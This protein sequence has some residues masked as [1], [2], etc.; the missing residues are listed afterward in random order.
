MT[1][2]EGET[3]PRNQYHITNIPFIAARDFRSTII[4]DPDLIEDAWDQK[5]E[6]CALVRNAV[7]IA[8][9]R[10]VHPVNLRLPV[11]D[12]FHNLPVAENDRQIGRLVSARQ[13]WTLESAV[14][15]YRSYTTSLLTIKGRIYIATAAWGPIS[16]KRYIS[17]GFTNTGKSYLDDRYPNP[18]WILVRGNVP[19]LTQELVRGH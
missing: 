15:F 6:H 1:S 11:S 16:I 9:Y 4:N 14:V 17:L 18:L 8:T 12:H 10:I 19:S 5:S 13:N 3:L 2:P 7:I